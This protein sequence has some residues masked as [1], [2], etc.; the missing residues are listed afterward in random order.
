MNYDIPPVARSK[1]AGN[2]AFMEALR[3]DEPETL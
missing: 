2:N 3:Y 1:R